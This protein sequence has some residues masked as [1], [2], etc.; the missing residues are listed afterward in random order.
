MK[1]VKQTV[2]EIL[3]EKLD[4]PESVLT[5]EANFIKD[6]GVDS[7]DY[8]EVVMAF[9]QAFG[10]NIPDTDTEKMRTVGA[11]IDYIEERL[12]SA[13]NQEEKVA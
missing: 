7:L 4:L 6:L 2:L 9:E 1:N 5:M 11:A 13:Q 10:I 12:A 3:K 8:I